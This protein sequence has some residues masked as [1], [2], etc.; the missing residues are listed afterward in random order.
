MP[1][2]E[3]VMLPCFVA[4]VGNQGEAAA[5]GCTGGIRR[6]VGCHVMQCCLL[7]LTKGVWVFSSGSQMTYTIE[8]EIEKLF[9]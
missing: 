4:L 2:H 5:S 9:A 8:D 7:V 3:L 6:M 1:R